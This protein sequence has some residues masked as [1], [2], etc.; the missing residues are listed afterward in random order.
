MTS[1]GIYRRAETEENKMRDTK[2]WDL[3]SLNVS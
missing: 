1:H 2:E 3:G